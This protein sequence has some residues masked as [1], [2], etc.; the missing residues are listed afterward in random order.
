MLH[1]HLSN[2]SVCS[3]VCMCCKKPYLYCSEINFHIERATMQIAMFLFFSMDGLS[4][5]VIQFQNMDE[6]L[7]TID[8]VSWQLLHMPRAPRLDTSNISMMFT[9]LQ[10]RSTPCSPV[11]SVSCYG[12]HFRKTK[13]DAIETAL[14]L[15]FLHKK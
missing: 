10:G 14:L 13:L 5:H 15:L 8:F 2:D 12:H 6:E 1:L 4:K 7:V 11:G 3:R 9:H